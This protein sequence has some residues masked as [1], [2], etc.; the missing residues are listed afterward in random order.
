MQSFHTKNIYL[1]G[2]INLIHCMEQIIF[3]KYK[4]Q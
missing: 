2:M 3:M 1:I 4:I